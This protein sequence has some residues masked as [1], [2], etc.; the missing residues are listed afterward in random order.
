MLGQIIQSNE[1]AIHILD[2][3][4]NHSK[5]FYAALLVDEQ[6]GFFFEVVKMKVYGYE[7]FENEIGGITIKQTPGHH[8]E[9]VIGLESSSWIIFSP[10]QIDRLCEDLQAVKKEMIEGGYNG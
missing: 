8:D 9:D 7:V 10:E 3:F 1:E 6:G 5:E 4:G 2:C